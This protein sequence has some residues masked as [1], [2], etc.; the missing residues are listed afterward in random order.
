[1]QLLT[2]VLNF[3]RNVSRYPIA[4]WG[5]TEVFGILRRDISLVMVFT[6]ISWGT[7]SITE[8]SGGRF[9]VFAFLG[10]FWR[11]AQLVFVIFSLAHFLC[12]YL[13]FISC[14]P[15]VLSP[16]SLA[17]CL[18]L[19]S[20]N[21]LPHF[22]DHL[23]P[24]FVV[25]ET[26]EV[27]CVPSYYRLWYVCLFACS[28]H[29]MSV[30]SILTACICGCVQCTRCTVNALMLLFCGNGYLFSLLLMRYK[31]HYFLVSI[32]ALE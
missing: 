24:N 18:A 9:K 16:C 14:K 8:V 15:R 22:A 32:F 28:Y 4:F 31:P 30:Q 26:L 10:T 25:S 19:N 5:V 3:L 27:H 11:T 21:Y 17:C 13:V 29:V 2:H 6:L 20:G 12:N 1:M 7:T 23:W